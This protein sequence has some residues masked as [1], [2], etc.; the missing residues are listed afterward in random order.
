MCPARSRR[1]VGDLSRMR[2]TF[3]AAASRLL[4]RGSCA[5]VAGASAWCR[6]TPGA[7]RRAAGQPR[8][9]RGARRRCRRRRPEAARAGRRH[10]DPAGGCQQGDRRCADRA[11]QRHRRPTGS[12]RQQAARQGRQRRDRRRAAAV[13]HLRRR[14]LRQRPVGL[15]SDRGRPRRHDRTAAAG[16]TLAASSQTGD[17]PTCSGPAPSR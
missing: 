1:A 17:R 8:Q 16:Q 15:L 4:R 13:R 7:G 14:H 2:R 12:R 3:G 11:G 6:P 5:A 10:S 9:P